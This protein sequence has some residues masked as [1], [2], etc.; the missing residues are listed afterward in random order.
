MVFFVHVL[1]GVFRI[2][3]V[4]PESHQ[5]RRTASCG[6]SLR[7]A[8][9]KGWMVRVGP[10]LHGN[11]RARLHEQPGVRLPARLRLNVAALLLIPVSLLLG[12]CSRAPEVSS[13]AAN[14]RPISTEAAPAA[15]FDER[16][17]APQFRDRFPSPTESF[18]QHQMS[19]F[20]P[21]PRW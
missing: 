14:A 16:F 6:C 12:Q 21:K 18:A 15:T 2:W 7:R 4:F 11:D 3:G 19:D 1:L 5:R 20:A 17:P 8:W 10:N 9:G 13:L